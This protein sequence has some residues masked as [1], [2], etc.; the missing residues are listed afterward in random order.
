MEK[1]TLMIIV[2]VIVVVVL[3]VVFLMNS[4]SQTDKWWNMNFRSNHPNHNPADILY[5]KK[6]DNMI[7]LRVRDESYTVPLNGNKIY[8]D[9]WKSTITNNYDGTMTSVDS[10]GNINNTFVKA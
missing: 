3:L 2:A 7:N 8:V 5:F 6:T 10:A 1:K 9:A 4:S